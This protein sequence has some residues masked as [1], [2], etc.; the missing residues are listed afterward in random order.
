MSGGL[1]CRRCNLALAPGVER[2]P[3]CLRTS[4]VVDPTR[5]GA[6]SLERDDART[7]SS[8]S[9]YAAWWMPVLIVVVHFGLG[10]AIYAAKRAAEFDEPSGLGAA[11]WVIFPYFG[12]VSYGVRAVTH[13]WIVGL[14]AIILAILGPL[15]LMGLAIGVSFLLVPS[16]GGT[17]LGLA[18]AFGMI[19]SIALA[20]LWAHLRVR[21]SIREEQDG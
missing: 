18:A 15:L 13:D 2:C 3:K 8:I 5:R 21:A 17:A 7:S 19:V 4:T 11:R 20:A 10:L 1:S 9:P 14:A 6:P 12:A 16:P